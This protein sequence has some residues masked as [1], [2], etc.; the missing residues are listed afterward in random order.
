MPG[1]PIHQARGRASGKLPGTPTQG[2]RMQTEAYAMETGPL[3]GVLFLK[4][5]GPSRS[6]EI[7]ARRK[8]PCDTL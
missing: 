7:Q 5:F 8:D 6:L 3:R 4:R 1:S 2:F